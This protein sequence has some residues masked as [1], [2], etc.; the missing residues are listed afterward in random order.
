MRFRLLGAQPTKPC[1]IVFLA[2][3]MVGVGIVR[4]HNNLLYLVLAILLVGCVWGWIGPALLSRT[5]RIRRKVPATGHAGAE[6][7]IEVEV[8]NQS[9]FLNAPM[10]ALENVN[11]IEGTGGLP[12]TVGALAP[13]SA[14]RFQTSVTLPRRGPLRFDDLRLVTAYPMGLF[15]R[16]WCIRDEAT[17]LVY[18]RIVRVRDRCLEGVTVNVSKSSRTPDTE[19][20]VQALRAYQQGDDLRRI[21]WKAT[22]RRDDLIVGDYHRV[23]KR[24]QVTLLLD[25]SA[26][27][28]QTREAA[29]SMVASLAVFYH[30]RHRL[31]QLVTAREIVSFGRSERK[32]TALLRLLALMDDKDQIPLK[33]RPRENGSSLKV[34]VHSGRAPVCA[35]S[36]DLVIAPR[37]YA[38]YAPA[39]QRSPS[40]A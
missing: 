17:I 23:E 21:N 29:I 27:D 19:R 9:R 18:P 12:V 33:H 2:T 36:C 6:I 26:G 3:L 35:K 10:I 5:V 38:R 31:I 34:L 16:E 4:T 24:A 11:S 32:M 20:E 14:V 7:G 30:A 22:A 25:I 39:L 37:D 1:G 40:H 13:S 15:E 8:L 28:D